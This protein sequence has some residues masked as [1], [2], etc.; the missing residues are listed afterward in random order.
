MK[1]CCTKLFITIFF[2]FNY[3]SGY[4]QEIIDSTTKDISALDSLKKAGYIFNLKKK[5]PEIVLSPEQAIRFLNQKTQSHYWK[6]PQDSLRLNLGQLIYEASHPRT[7]SIA[8]FLS[9][10]A[11]I[12]LMYHGISSL[13][14]SR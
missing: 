2:V 8:K 12:R 7:D 5:E 10:T 3:L 4:S 11:M 14:G 9:D 1:H 13:Y 6:N